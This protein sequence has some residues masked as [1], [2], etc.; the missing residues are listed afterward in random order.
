MP[1]GQ[2]KGQ[3]KVLW[4]AKYPKISKLFDRGPLKWAPSQRCSRIL[5]KR[6]CQ[7]IWTLEINSICMFICI[8]E[9]LKTD[10]DLICENDTVLKRNTKAGNG[11]EQKIG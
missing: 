2:G 11:Q 3:S 9:L 4:N 10:N 5:M 6:N 7:P 1:A 8:L